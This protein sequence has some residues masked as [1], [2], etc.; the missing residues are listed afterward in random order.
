M[1]NASPEAILLT[2]IQKGV[3]AVVYNTPTP[4]TAFDTINGNRALVT[5]RS[6]LERLGMIQVH[7]NR[8][9]LTQSGKNAIISNNIADQSGEMTEDGTAMIDAV[10]ALLGARTNEGFVLLRSLIS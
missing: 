10:N 4:E 7:G 8:V 1:N 9:V 5:A 3:L 6:I 2:D